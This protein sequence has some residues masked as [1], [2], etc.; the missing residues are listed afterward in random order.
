MTETWTFFYAKEGLHF[1]KL[2]YKGW[3]LFPN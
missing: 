1:G 2:K 3:N